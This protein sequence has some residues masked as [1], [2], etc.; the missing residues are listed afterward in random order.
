M[1]GAIMEYD[2]YLCAIISDEFIKYCVVQKYHLHSVWFSYFKWSFPENNT[3]VLKHTITN[4]IVAEITKISATNFLV[5]TERTRVGDDVIYRTIIMR[6]SAE[7]AVCSLYET[8]KNYQ[9]LRLL[10]FE[11]GEFTYR[12]GSPNTRVKDCVSV[13]DQIT[14]KEIVAIVAEFDCYN[15]CFASGNS[16]GVYNRGT[17]EYA[18]ISRLFTHLKESQGTFDRAWAYDYVFIWSDTLV[19]KDAKT[20]KIVFQF[21]RAEPIVNYLVY[22]GNDSHVI[23]PSYM[24]GHSVSGDVCFDLLER[25]FT[26]K[27]N[28][29]WCRETVEFLGLTWTYRLNQ[30]KDKAAEEEASP[31][32]ETAQRMKIECVWCEF[33]AKY[34]ELR[35]KT[36]GEK[37]ATVTPSTSTEQRS[38][39]V[40]ETQRAIHRLDDFDAC[41][42]A[43]EKDAV[44]LIEERRRTIRSSIATDVELVIESP[45]RDNG[46]GY[47]KR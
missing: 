33:K 17:E 45:S 25:L 37:F 40:G 3:A 42:R 13:I 5:R 46:G 1:K 15:V 41:K 39:Y 8:V 14:G 19:I 26:R 29:G 11:K 7:E 31:V 20:G 34:F 38:R 9:V 23:E 10:Q 2:P 6:K 24:V 44:K 16:V 27:E 12:L 32:T 28:Y 35:D 36:T 22:Y 43:V 47:D 21:V 4:E 30:L 18:A